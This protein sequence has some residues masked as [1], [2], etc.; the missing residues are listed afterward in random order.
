MQRDYVFVEGLDAH[1]RSLG[2]YA[3]ASPSGKTHFRVRLRLSRGVDV[4]EVHWVSL[5]LIRGAPPHDH[6]RIFVPV[7]S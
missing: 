7:V 2:P 3:F 4:D 1:R 6:K 5:T